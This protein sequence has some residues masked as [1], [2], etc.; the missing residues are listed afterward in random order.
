MTSSSVPSSE[1]AAS[2]F[3]ARGH[4]AAVLHAHA[5]PL[6]R[7]AEQDLLD[8][9]VADEGRL[10]LLP[11]RSQLDFLGPQHRD[12]LVAGGASAGAGLAGGAK[13]MPSLLR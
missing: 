3:T 8:E 1:A 4:R 12:D 11:F 6:D 7:A 5:Q 9:R 13:R 2:R 10:E